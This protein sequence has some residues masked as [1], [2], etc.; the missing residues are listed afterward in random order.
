VCSNEGQCIDVDPDSMSFFV[1]S[2]GNLSG[3]FGGLDGADDY[4]QGLAE[5]AGSVRQWHAYLSTSAVDARDRIG[6]GPWFNFEGVEIAASVAALHQD[7]LFSDDALDEYGDPV[8]NGKT[9]PGFNEHDVLTG[10]N[11]DGTWSG[12]DCDGWTSNGD[13]SATTGHC[14]ASFTASGG[15]SPVEPSDNW[16]SAHETNGCDQDRLNG[17]GS[18]ARIYCFSGG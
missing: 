4:C 18:T 11:Q 6:T 1:T 12:A 3:D 8:P 5:A 16:N 15:S 13:G 2:A 7:G 10:S 9:N 17:T 14:D